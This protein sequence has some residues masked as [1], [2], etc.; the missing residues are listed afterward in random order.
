MQNTKQTS[1]V[2]KI[3]KNQS[4]YDGE[5][6]IICGYRGKKKKYG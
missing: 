4:V 1:G 5:R 6:R 3:D 2:L